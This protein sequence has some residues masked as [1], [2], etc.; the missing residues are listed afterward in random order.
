MLQAS[1]PVTDEARDLL[2]EAQ[3]LI[4]GKA[5]TAKK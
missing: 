5:A 2:R 1:N 3:E 4:E